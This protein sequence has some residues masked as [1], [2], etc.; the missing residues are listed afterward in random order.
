[1]NTTAVLFD[2]DGTLM[3]S[4]RMVIQ[5]F[6]HLF[7]KY[8]DIKDFTPEIQNEVFG[9]PLHVEM[10]KHFQNQDPDFMV[11]EYRDFQQSQTW[12]DVMELFP[13]AIE[14][15][16]FLQKN[17]ILMG[18]VSSR[19]TN[20]CNEW[21][22]KF[23]IAS[24][25]SVVLGRDLFEKAK[26]EPDG[27]LDAGRILHAEQNQCIYVGDNASDVIAAKRAGVYSVGFISEES[28]REAILKTDPDAC[29]RDLIELID[30]VKGR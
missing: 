15:L 29:I 13:H 8:G 27:I 10:E 12:D 14:T 24:Y 26:P 25:F 22:H 4:H 2:L 9:P 6:A 7:E 18:I 3:D 5:C 1:M 20:S 19:I 30:I 16:S 21:L 23:G 11:R 17:K 28:A